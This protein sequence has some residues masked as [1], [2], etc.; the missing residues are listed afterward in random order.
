MRLAGRGESDSLGGPGCSA[1]PLFWKTKFD[2]SLLPDPNSLTLHG[3][4]FN[5]SDP[6][7]EN[8]LS[9]AWKQNFPRKEGLTGSDSQLW[10]CGGLLNQVRLSRSQCVR[11]HP[12][13]P[14][15]LLPFP[16]QRFLKLFSFFSFFQSFPSSLS[17][18]TRLSPRCF[19]CRALFKGTHHGTHTTDMQ[20]SVVPL[21][22]SIHFFPF[23]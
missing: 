4:I 1:L 8:R 12:S 16:P 3:W 6:D 20:N 5:F 11:R 2:F 10:R 14:S 17:L 7:L 9:I 13:L 23:G 18:S 15:F 21:G 22:E 19:V